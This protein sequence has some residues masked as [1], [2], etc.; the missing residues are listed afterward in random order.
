MFRGVWQLAR[1][2]LRLE[3]MRV[4]PNIVRFLLAFLLL[5][6][7]VEAR[8]N[9]SGSAQGLAI[10]KSQVLLT[11]LFL[12]I[13]AVFG[14]S[15][16]ISEEREAGTLDLMRLAGINS[17]AVVLGKSLP[18]FWESL[19][20]I[21]VQ[22]P[23]TI[24]AITLGGL[25]WPQVI[26]AY[27]YLLA[28]L[29]LVAGIGLF[30]SAS[31]R[32]SK[33]A[34][35]MSSLITFLYLLP[36]VFS[37][38]GG[39]STVVVL[40]G[41]FSLQMRTMELM[42]SG[43]QNSPW[44]LA[45]YAAVLTGCCLAVAACFNLHRG[46]ATQFFTN[47]ILNIL[48]RLRSKGRVWKSPF[49][50]LDFTFTSG[51]LWRMSIRSVAHCSLFAWMYIVMGEPSRAFAWAA[52]LGIVVSLVDATWSASRLFSDEIRN[53]TWSVLVQTPNTLSRILIHKTLGWLLGMSPAI[54]LPYLFIFLAIMLFPFSN[55][56]DDI[57]ELIIGSLVS[58]L[59][60]IAYLH[61]MAYFTLDWHW[62]AIPASLTVTCVLVYIYI[63]MLVPWQSGGAVRCVV[64]IGT[65]IVLL[66]FC[67]VLQLFIHKRLKD[68]AGEG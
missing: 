19:L 61:L 3:S 59:G 50:W 4:G 34:V 57:A 14:F 8:S 66:V 21:G 62:K 5:L 20:L 32:T 54:L 47:P 18:R 40:L 43:F 64:F 56:L 42:M 63:F 12:T 41:N 45:V 33:A 13:N 30:C 46:G 37:I 36:F 44:C 15:Q 24:L 51:G 38:L 9:T 25:A 52:L 6:V 2:A 65:G 22:F 48:N 27:V 39:G 7:I 55:G 49:L 31:Y 16:L 60:V 29:C 58:G 68:L 11:H 67:M 53:H 26:A 17:I 28:Y 35:V 10:F 23:F 1:R